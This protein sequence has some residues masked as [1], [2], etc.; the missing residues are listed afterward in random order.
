MPQIPA[1][2]PYVIRWA[3]EHDMEELPRI[4]HAA[5]QRFTLTRHAAIAGETPWSPAEYREWMRARG[6]LVAAGRGDVAVGFALLRPLGGRDLC[7]HELD[8]HPSHGRRGVGRALVESACRVAARRGHARVVLSTFVDVPWN[9]PFYR[10]IG[11]RDLAPRDATEALREVRRQ[12]SLAG[13]DIGVRTL[14][15]RWTTPRI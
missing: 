1:E 6:L 10:R 11:F 8:V 2:P 13:L 3:R 12:E 4:E 14:M 9:A 7:L 5:V 15:A